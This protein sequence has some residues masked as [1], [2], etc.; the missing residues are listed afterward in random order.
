[1]S[2]L[3]RHTSYIARQSL[4]SSSLLPVPHVNSITYQKSGIADLYYVSLIKTLL[5]S[6]SVVD[7]I[8]KN[9]TG[10]LRTY[11]IKTTKSGHDYNQ[12]E[13]RDS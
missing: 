9:N 6:R 5:L 13:G 10:S 4:I 3:I 8:K 2:H 1:M 7:L 12:I 11:L